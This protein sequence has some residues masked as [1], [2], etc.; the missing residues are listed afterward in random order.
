MTPGIGSD[1]LKVAIEELY[2]FLDRSMRNFTLGGRT[3]QGPIGRQVDSTF[4]FVAFSRA[5]I[6]DI[7]KVGVVVHSAT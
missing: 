7:V 6:I 2:D 3:V 5:N 1:D 4:D